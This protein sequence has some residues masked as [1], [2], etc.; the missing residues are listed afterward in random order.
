M[1]TASGMNLAITA[2][3]QYEHWCHSA[4]WVW[5]EH[6]PDLTEVMAIGFA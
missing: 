4:A 5:C 2:D 1:L 6:H 3:E